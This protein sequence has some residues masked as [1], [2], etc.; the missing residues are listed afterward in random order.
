MVLAF[1]RR[2]DC[3]FAVN[4]LERPRGNDHPRHLDVFRR[5]DLL[6]AIY[7]LGCELRALGASVLVAQIPQ[8]SSAKVGLDDYWSGA[9][10]LAGSKCSRSVIGFLKAPSIGTLNGSSKKR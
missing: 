7:A 5:A 2:A 8:P 9:A 1:E 6:Q 10:M 4:R 3:G